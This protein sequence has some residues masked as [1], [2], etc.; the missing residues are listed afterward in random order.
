[1]PKKVYLVLNRCLGCEECSRACANAHNPNHISR[2][3]VETIN[4]FLSFSLRCAHCSEPSC[5][6]VCDQDAIS[7]TEEDIVL[8]DSEK[9]N[10]CGNC[11]VACPFGMIQLDT[12]SKKALKCDMCI[13]RLREGNEPACVV[14]CALS[15]LVYGDLEDLESEHD[16]EV[17]QKVLEIGSLLR[18]LLA[19]KE[20]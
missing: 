9:C 17:G 1:M 10:G 12:V 6:P 7:K 3:F 11:V 2:N 16:K 14:N 19:I 13:D 5:L 15:A 8:I 20:G 4:D 18:E